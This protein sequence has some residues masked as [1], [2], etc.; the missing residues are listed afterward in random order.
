MIGQVEAADVT[1]LWEPLMIIT[2]DGPAASGK[3]TVAR[4]LAHELS[5][6][7]LYSGLLYRA[8]AHVL[9]YYYGYTRGQL[10]KP[11]AEDVREII[12]GRALQYLYSVERGAQ[13][14]WDGNDI[15]P[16]LKTHEID[17][18]ASLGST[19]LVVRDAVLELQRTLA[20]NHDVIAD[21]RDCGT[22]VFP[23]AS[24]KFFLTA[25]S[26]TRAQ[27]W[28]LDQQ[29]LGK[30]MTFEQAMTAVLGRD[31]RDTK[32]ACCPLVIP[33]GAHVIDN[34][35]LSIEETV[36]LFARSIH[37]SMH[38]TEQRKSLNL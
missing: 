3:S 23:D 17:D 6:Y 2:I 19:A 5:Y 1:N 15:T 26:Q 8:M 35:L 7:Y 14:F 24:H 18:Y 30:Q 32:R 13:I 37:A 11:L 12:E 25:S 9:V 22:V 36:T 28:L 38:K 33:Q 29:R 4:Q 20:K 27:R 21:G 34:S 16:Q 10:A 31:E